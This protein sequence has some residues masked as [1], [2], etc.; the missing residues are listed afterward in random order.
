MLFRSVAVSGGRAATF[1]SLNLINAGQLPDLPAGVF[2]ETPTVV[3]SQGAHPRR[4]RLPE[5]VVR[6][7]R[8]QAEIN[9]LIV[10]G[11]L[12]SQMARLDE[13]LELDPTVLDK[14]AGQQALRACIAA[15]PDVMPV[16]HES[17]T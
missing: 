8:P 12:T 13:A 11:A 15:H 16:F 5:P 2:V 17:L 1:H 10:Q 3:D 6:L 4:L 14:A 7:N 9:D